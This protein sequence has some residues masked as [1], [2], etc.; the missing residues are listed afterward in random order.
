MPASLR[1]GKDPRTG[2]YERDIGSWKWLKNHRRGM[3]QMRNKVAEQVCRAEANV[4]R[5]ESS[6]RRVA[7]ELDE[8][9]AVLRERRADL[10]EQYVRKRRLDEDGV[11][12]FGQPTRGQPRREDFPMNEEQREWNEELRRLEDAA[13]GERPFRCNPGP[14]PEAVSAGLHVGSE[15]PP[16]AARWGAGTDA[17]ASSGAPASSGAAASSSAA[18]SSAGGPARADT[19]EEAQLQVFLHAS[20]I[21]AGQ[22]AAETSDY[23][24]AQVSPQS[25]GA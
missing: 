13:E 7:R 4:A 2:R 10:D 15:P 16:R 20:A 1:G 5:L 12:V 6:A 8:A 3:L 21:E 23:S 11:V 22:G 18:A 19:L 25:P 17:Q 24:A 14:T 9:I